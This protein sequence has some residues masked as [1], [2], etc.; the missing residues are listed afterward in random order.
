[1]SRLLALKML[2]NDG[3]FGIGLRNWGTS[4]IDSI[5]LALA[6]FGSNQAIQVMFGFASLIVRSFHAK[7]MISRSPAAGTNSTAGQ[8][9]KLL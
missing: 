2:Q 4:Q 5:T 6:E 3:N 9:P 8:K 7:L 1:M